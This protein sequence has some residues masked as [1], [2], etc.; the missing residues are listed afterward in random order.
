MSDEQRGEH[1]GPREGESE[2]EW[3]QRM[4]S[5]ELRWLDLFHRLTSRVEANDEE[6]KLREERIQRNIE[7][8]V[9]Q[10]AQFQVKTEAWREESDARHARIEALVERLAISSLRRFEKVEGEVSELDRKMDALVDSHIRLA[11]SQKE[12]GERLDAFIATVE[13]LIN[14]RRNGRRKEPG[15]LDE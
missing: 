8:I 2:H 15:G 3:M 6:A 1:E 13:R 5:P 7:F 4:T 11:D 12:T 9:Q 10:Q 14:E